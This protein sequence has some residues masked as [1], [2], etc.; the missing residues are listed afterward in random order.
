MFLLNREFL[1][2]RDHGALRNILRRDLPPTTRIERRILRLL[3]YS[4]KIEY[5]RSQDNVVADV[6]L[7]LPF[8][9][10]QKAN[11]SLSSSPG[12]QHTTHILAATNADSMTAIKAIN[13]SSSQQQPSHPEGEAA[14]ESSAIQ[15]P[16]ETFV[17]ADLLS[18]TFTSTLKITQ[19]L[20]TNDP[21]TSTSGTST[22]PILVSDSANSSSNC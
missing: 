17:P 12:S 20:S 18:T 9:T 5:L 1:L 6:R 7:R 13:E 11:N 4:F 8:A 22:T 10:A 19:I 15:Q 2:R 16:A 21:R 3:A 14:I